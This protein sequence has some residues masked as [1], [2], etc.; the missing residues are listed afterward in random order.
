LVGASW[1]LELT[2]APTELSLSAS[3]EAAASAPPLAAWQRAAADLLA[4]PQWIWDDTDKKGRPRQRDLRSVLTWLEV[5]PQGA[6][7]T[8]RV[9]ARID[10]LGRSLRPEQLQHWFASRLG[11]PLL[12]RRFCRDQL[13][14]KT[15]V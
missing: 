1:T 12:M 9:G 3:Q 11:R 2:P 13:E 7:V 14:L 5:E 15:G 4:A 8:I 10:G 6:A